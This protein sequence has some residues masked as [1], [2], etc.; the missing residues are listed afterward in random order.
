MRRGKVS[1]SILFDWENA[2]AYDFN[3]AVKIRTM[4]TER[5]VDAYGREADTGEKVIIIQGVTN[6]SY[7]SFANHLASVFPSDAVVHIGYTR[8]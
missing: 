6:H 3:R 7:V 8:L 2:Q 1:L 5:T 4:F